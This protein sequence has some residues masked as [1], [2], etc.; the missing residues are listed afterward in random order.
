MRELASDVYMLPGF[1]SYLINTY[2]IG[3]VL[4]DASTKLAAN[5]L[6][7]KLRN[8]PLSAHA[9][10]HVH[11]DHQG[12]SHALCEAFSLPL[13]CPDDEIAAMEAGDMSTQIPRSTLTRFRDVIWTG[14]AHPVDRGLRE[15][16]EVAGFTVIDAPGHSPG[17]IAYWRESDGIL[18][19]GDVL[20][21]IDFL[22]LQTGLQEPPTA[23]TLD[24]AKN[25][26]SARKLANLR[27]SLVCFGHGR[28]VD[29]ETFCAF[30][31]N[32]EI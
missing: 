23:F 4:I 25:R 6:K 9:L 7:R 2:L 14:P 29:G 28:P 5:G 27:P 24:A 11:P 10:T 1:P 8:R 17:Q 22:T 21:N 30:V 16:D 26:D 3:D 12:A 18:I 19:A 32:L 15:G 20:I 31:G 13:W